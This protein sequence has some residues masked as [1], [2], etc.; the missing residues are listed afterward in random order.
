[1]IFFGGSL[2]KPRHMCLGPCTIFLDRQTQQPQLGD[3]LGQEQKGTWIVIKRGKNRIF[4]VSCYYCYCYAFVASF[5]PFFSLVIVLVASV[6]AAIVV[7]CCC[8]CCCCALCFR[9]PA[10]LR[11]TLC[12]GSSSKFLCSDVHER[13]FA[14]GP[15]IPNNQNNYDTVLALTKQNHRCSV[16]KHAIFQSSIHVG[17]FECRCTVVHIV[18]TGFHFKDQRLTNSSDFI[19]E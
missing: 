4:I 16:V 7:V 12:E 15:T 17:V 8:W 11:C 9:Y 18:S 19:H 5:C 2:Q 3:F 10:K 1:M 14:S 6:V 13:S